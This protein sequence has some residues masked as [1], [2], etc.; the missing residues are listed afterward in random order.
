MGSL[1]FTPVYPFPSASGAFQATNRTPS[2]YQNPFAP[3]PPSDQAIIRHALGLLGQI[4]N[5]PQDEQ[6]MRHLG[7]YPGFQNGQQALGVIQSKGIQ[8]EFGD[9][10][11]SPAHAQWISDENK[12]MINQRYKG[13]SSPATLYAI[14]EAIYHEAGHAAGNG[15]GES[16]IQEELNCLGLNTLAYRYHAATDPGY[17]QSALNNRLLSDG[18][19]LYPKLFFDPDPSKK[20]LIQRVVQKYGDL[21]LSSPGHPV[22]LS[23]MPL[24][25]RVK[26]QYQQ[27]TQRP[28]TSPA[29]PTP[30]LSYEA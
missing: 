14:S 1:S 29:G 3:P 22:P 6:Y 13:D 24:A 18:V 9:M 8:V 16:S 2:L 30:Q 20:A 19:A 17:A 11:D 10:G 27:Q 4:K 26:Y 7:V 28:G 21:P 15:D 12:I 5:L 25:S 23:P